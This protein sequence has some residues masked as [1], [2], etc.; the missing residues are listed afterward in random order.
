ML[1]KELERRRKRC[2]YVLVHWPEAEGWEGEAFYAIERKT[3]LD[4]WI[5]D[6]D[7]TMVCDHQPR[8]VLRG[9]LKLLEGNNVS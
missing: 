6:E 8:S 9:M 1:E 7:Y 5:E 3:N 2:K 4:G